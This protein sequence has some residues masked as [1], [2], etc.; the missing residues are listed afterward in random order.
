LDG[1]LGEAMNQTTF[2]WSVW[3]SLCGK[4][5]GRSKEVM[6]LDVEFC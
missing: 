2:D 4:D 5:N 3:V 1:V 6:E